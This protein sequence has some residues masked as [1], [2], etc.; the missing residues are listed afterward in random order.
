MSVAKTGF[1]HCSI[2]SFPKWIQADSVDMPLSIC[3]PD[4]VFDKCKI[5]RSWK[6]LE[7]QGLL[8]LERV[9]DNGFPVLADSHGIEEDV[10]HSQLEQNHLGELCYVEHASGG[11]VLHEDQHFAEVSTCC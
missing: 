9:V 1:P 11:I 6:W 3:L 2:V 8:Q 10:F 5:R 7:K 4:R